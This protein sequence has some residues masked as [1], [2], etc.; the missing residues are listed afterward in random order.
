MNYWPCFPCALEETQLPL[1]D[2]IKEVS[3]SGRE[4]ASEIYGAPGFVVHH[5]V[6][7]WATSWPMGNN[8]RGT[9]EYAA[10]NFSAAWFCA[11]LFERYEYTLD[12][13]FLE[14]TAYPLMKEAALF[15][16]SLLSEDGNGHLWFCPSTS[17]ENGFIIDGK[18]F[19]MA[20]T[21]AMSMAIIRELFSNCVKAAG[22]LDTDRDFAAGLEKKIPLLYP[23]QIGSKGQLLEWDGEYEEADPKHRHISHL[24]GLHPGHQIRPD[25]TPDLAAACRKSLE[26][27][28]DDG[29]GWSLAWK[30][31]MWARL[32]DGN[33]A[34]AILNNQ[35]RLVEEGDP[36]YAG[37]GGT[38]PN[39][40]C[41]HPPFQIDGNYGISAGFTEMLLQN[42]PNGIHLLPALPD[43]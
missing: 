30:V 5:N 1:I 42:T 26:L 34:L 2:L 8:G 14:E 15:V 13:A 37:W 4:S 29:T 7:L 3:V 16:D 25:E 41:A 11:H 28:G 27:R 19:N 24:Y 32:G 22:I 43:S 23:F 21:A 39:M 10:W 12:T 36:S 6:D 20:R 18:R 17:P 33:H 40:F 35:L 9:C 31:N 38:Y